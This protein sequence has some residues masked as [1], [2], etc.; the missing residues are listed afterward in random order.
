MAST[1]TIPKSRMV[2]KMLRVEGLITMIIALV[3]AIYCK[4]HWLLIL[5]LF[6]TF[7]ITLLGYKINPR[8][9]AIM[10]NI[11]H[12]LSLPLPLLML[13]IIL[14]VPLLISICLLWIGHIGYDKMLG[15]G[16]KYPEKFEDTY[17]QHV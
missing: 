6:F 5:A 2:Y 15:F 9:G 16:L 11:G 10:Y 17:L 14:Q 7:D 4:T 13:G 8:I 12:T 1:E 3:A